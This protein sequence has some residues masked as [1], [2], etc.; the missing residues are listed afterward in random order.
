MGAF[1]LN[2]SI[3]DSANLA[4]KIGLCAKGHASIASLMP[5]YDSER[6]LHAN[7]VLEVSGTYLRF[8]SAVDL[9]VVNLKDKGKPLGDEELEEMEE[10][11][12]RTLLTPD[13]NNASPDQAEQRGYLLD[14]F[15]KHGMFLLCLDAAYGRSVLNPPPKE[16]ASSKS[17]PPSLVPLTVKNGVRAP[18]PRVCFDA[19]N[20]GYLYDKLAGQPRFHL[21]VFGSDLLGPVRRHLAAFAR[22]LVNPKGFYRRFGGSERFN[23]VLVAKG[24]PFEVNDRM[25]PSAT[26]ENIGPL[27]G[28][29]TVLYDDRPPDE[30]AHSTYGVNHSTGAIAVVRPDLWMGMGLAISETDEID[31]YFTQFLIPVSPLANGIPKANGTPTANGAPTA[32]G[33]R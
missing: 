13:S 23:L 10:G 27:A 30:D 22:E 9:G 16:R 28:A 8:V 15:R 32:N 17:F 1:G 4:W 18:N 2:L 11:E 29:A 6:R 3:I 14:Y 33:T 12:N 5:T 19:N 25:E 24:I 21:V 20:T 7:N 31:K 26:I